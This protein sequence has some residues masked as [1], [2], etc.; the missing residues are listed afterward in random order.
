[1]FVISTYIWRISKLKFQQQLAVTTVAY[2]FVPVEYCNETIAPRTERIHFRM[3]TIPGAS[4]QSFLEPSIVS[5]LRD[6]TLLIAHGICS[7]PSKLNNKRSADKE[8]KIDLMVKISVPGH[9][10]ITLLISMETAR[11]YQEFVTSHSA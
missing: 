8:E 5:A 1:M 2:P 7:F 6:I 3:T 4:S 10:L 9:Q 11:N